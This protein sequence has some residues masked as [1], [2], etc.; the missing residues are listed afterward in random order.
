MSSKKQ[1][2]VVIL[3]ATATGKTDLGIWLAKK[4]NGEIVSAD[5]RLVYR[6]MDIGTAKPK[7]ESEVGFVSGEIDHHMIDISSLRKIYNVATYKK[8]A[9]SEIKKIGKRDK[10]AFLVGGTGLYIDAIVK[11]IDFPGIKSDNGLRKELE[12]KTLDELNNEYEKLDPLGSK[13]ID[14][15]NKRRLIRAI[16]VCRLT[17][18]SFWENRRLEEPIFD[19]LE[20]GMRIDKEILYTRIAKRIR[21]MIKM[22]LEE[23]AKKLILKYGDVP[24]L[25]TIGYQ[26]WREYVDKEIDKKELK[27]IEERIILNTNKFSKRQNT[28][29]KRDEK[30]CWIESKK[31]A[32]KL[33]K[34]FLK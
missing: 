34:D 24:P 8:K 23:E 32:E 25:Q 15:N 33:V 9:V 3:G 2:L 7:N 31:E 18:K 11:N 17:G 5:S 13:E 28:W 30:I 16:E 22:G 29:F 4:F 1:K 27:Q 19:C 26:E 6:E 14:K 20:I 21:K 10:L 12:E